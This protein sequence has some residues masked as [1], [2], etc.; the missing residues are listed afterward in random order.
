MPRPGVDVEIVDGAPAGSAALNTGTAFMTGVTERGPVGNAVRVS[1]PSKYS[2]TFGERSGGSLLYDSVS[3]F[4]AEGGGDLYISRIAGP[5]SVSATGAL[6][7]TLTA[8]AKSPGA[9]ANGVK[10]D[11][12]APTLLEAFRTPSTRAGATPP[13][14][15]TVTYDGDVVERSYSLADTADAIAWA[16]KHSD[17]VTL[18]ASAI[19]NPAVGS[20]VTLAGGVDDSVI[21]DASLTA[22][23]AAF[24]AGFGPGQVLAP[25]LTDHEAYAA[26]CDH[27]DTF[28]RVCL[29]DAPDSSD[30]SVLAAAVASL[31]GHT[32][33][34]YAAMFGPWAVYPA[35]VSPATVV[36][37][38]SAVEAGIIA[39]VDRGGNPNAP[40]AGED[41]IAKL[42]VA[43]AQ[44]YTDAE[45]EALNG[46]GVDLAK[47]VYGDVRT[48]GYR[49][50]AGPLDDNWLWFGGSRTLMALA[51]EC[52]AIAES[53]VLKQIDGR[54]Q[55]FSRLNKDLRGVCARFYDMGAL[56]GE[57][58]SEAFAVITDESVN[59]TE[60]IKAGEIHAVVKVRVSPAAEWV[61]IRIVKV[62]VDQPVAA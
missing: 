53:Y 43:L 31:T 28:R 39:R 23:L 22:A 51:W 3:A 38:Y 6:G 7:T 32:G 13:V 52:E 61:V 9:W 58:G 14:V 17:Y 30:A 44:T 50:A 24:E 57:S 25:G 18:T 29:L 2:A 21:D 27:A 11:A 1:S 16:D 20:T 60:T 26:L 46:V 56:Y 62:P 42:A 5:N 49:T 59:T 40:A 33:V 10:V 37:P 45:R 41:G 54:R 4:F 15:L 8:D 47:V 35:E 34:R 48:Y 19:D 55:I 12:V 36:V